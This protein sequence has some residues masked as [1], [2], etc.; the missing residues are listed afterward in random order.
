MNNIKV[1]QENK[2]EYIYIDTLF[3][4]FKENK[5]IILPFTFI[6]T[7]IALIISNKIKPTYFAS[8]QL[9]LRPNNYLKYNYE[10]DKNNSLILDEGFCRNFNSNTLT[11]LFNSFSQKYNFLNSSNY[12]SFNKKIKAEVIRGTKLIQIN[13]QTKNKENII[14]IINDYIKFQKSY[15]QSLEISCYKEKISNLNSLIKI[16]N[17]KLFDKNNNFNINEEINIEQEEK[18]L[19]LYKELLLNL[20]YNKNIHSS[21]WIIT[22]APQINSKEYFPGK[23]ETFILLFALDHAFLISL[24]LLKKKFKF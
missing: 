4:I 20:K 6:I 9:L 23:I 18:L 5:K 16:S 22:A 17:S 24:I 3:N 21:D 7:I 14:P 15:I 13:Y 2:D 19:K 8:A 12:K 1:A 10:G 11:E